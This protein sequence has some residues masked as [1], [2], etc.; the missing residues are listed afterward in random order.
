MPDAS[1]YVLARQLETDI[2]GILSLVDESDLTSQLKQT[3]N[4]I[5]HGITDA[6]LDVR[7]YDLADTRAEQVKAAKEVSGRLQM[8]RQQILVASQHNIFSA[9]D[10]AHLSARIDSIIELAV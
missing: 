10:V 6:R 8:V 7:D 3:L 4:N 1:P 2:R 5:K 9:I